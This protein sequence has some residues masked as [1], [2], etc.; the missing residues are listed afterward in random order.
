LE[1]YV[2]KAGK[3]RD[4]LVSIAQALGIKAAQ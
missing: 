4:Q 3:V 2:T 1:F